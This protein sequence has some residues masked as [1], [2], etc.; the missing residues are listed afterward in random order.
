MHGCMSEPPAILN[1]TH[2]RWEGAWESP[3]DRGLAE[4]VH[5]A[6]VKSLW[7]HAPQVGPCSAAHNTKNATRGVPNNVQDAAQGV[8]EALEGVRSSL[9]RIF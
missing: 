7:M 4:A 6:V 5:S 1:R 3:G 2:V 9:G 8:V